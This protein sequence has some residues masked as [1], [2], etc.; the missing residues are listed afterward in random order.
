MDA[1]N[2]FWSGVLQ[3][4]AP[5]VTPDWG[6]LVGLLPLLLLVPVALYLVL[7]VRAWKRLQAA[8]PASLKRRPNRRAQLVL[9]AGGVLLGGASVALAFAVAGTPEAGTI[10]VTVSI[11]LL[12]L[13][14]LIAVGTVGH[15]IVVWESGTVD[16]DTGEVDPSAAWVAEHRR[17][18]SL[19]LQF[20]VGVA[21]AAVGLLLLPPADATGVQ[22]VATVPV[23]VLGLLLAIAAVGRAV[24][25]FWNDDDATDLVPSDAGGG[26]A[27]PG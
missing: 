9:H 25:G 12:I 7:T 22:P 10:G 27:N 1:L 17:P 11:P 20:V 5:V 16:E 18:I 14:V 13:G 21:I 23:L 6:A 19:V 3:L 8:Q 24:A 2:S 15:G 26:V 4:L